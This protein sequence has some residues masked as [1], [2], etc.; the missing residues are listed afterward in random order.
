MKL[1]KLDRKDI[2]LLSVT[3]LFIWFFLFYSGYLIGLVRDEG[4]YGHAAKEMARW[5]DYLF[6][7]WSNGELFKPFS[8]PVIDRYFRYNNEHPAVI[9][10]LFGFSVYIFHNKLQL[11]E[12]IPSIRLVAAL[13][14]AL[15]AGMIYLFGRL[16]FN[17]ETAIAAPLL[18]F[19]MP[20]IFFHAHL[21]C[22]DMP[23]LFF[24]SATLL[25]YLVHLVK[26]TW[27]S[28]ITPALLLGVGL[29]VKHNMFFM[30]ILL[31]LVHVVAYGLSYRSLQK[32]YRGFKGFVL[33]VPPVFYLFV[34]VSLPLYY[35]LW[36]WLWYDPWSR[37][38]GYM[39]FHTQHVNY[40]NYYFGQELT[41]APFPFSFPWGMTFFTTPLPQLILFIAGAIWL[42]IKSVSLKIKATER[43]IWL[44]LSVAIFFPILLIALPSVPIFG[45]I[46]HWF[47][48][49]PLLL[50]VGVFVVLHGIK[51]S[52]P[53][54]RFSV[55]LAIMTL[56]L[57]ALIP[58]NIKFARHGAAFFN[59][60]IGGGQGAANSEMQRNFWGYDIL[61]LTEKLN[62]TAPKNARLFIAGYAEGLN[63]DAFYYLRDAGVIRRD[64]RPTNNI[65]ES[66]FAFFFY[67][68][69]NESVLYSIF[70]YYGTVKPLAITVVDGV[71]Y[72][73]LYRRRSK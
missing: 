73:G 7:S 11:L 66:D 51:L 8:Q 2:F 43:E 16:F 54:R 39:A 28:G 46:K 64:I 17:R 49:Y 27:T 33:S 53:K 9:K 56:A 32:N 13:F 23:V 72:S 67:E 59:Q 20:H 70:R 24:W 15:T 6:S 18:F 71:Y 44:Q 58:L 35:I 31:L 29:G 45:G 25:F 3:M 47:T 21:A 14:G 19:T 1:Q 50:T 37:F 38:L 10:E 42:G 36:P 22:F 69:Q 68:K 4:F 26:R 63:M 40:T 52:L 57:V 5:F 55:G 62:E 12:F 60:L 30:P 41:R 34:V 65:A 61:D 48:G